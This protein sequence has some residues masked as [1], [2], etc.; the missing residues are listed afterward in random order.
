VPTVSAN[1]IEI[2]YERQ[3]SGPRLLFFNGSG[4]TLRTSGALLL[5]PFAERF[6][7]LAHDQRGLGETSVP[8]GPYTMA[9]YAADG[10]ALLDALGWDTCNVFGV[11]FGGMVAQEFAVTYPSRVTRL[12]LACTS[13]GGAGGS[14]YPLH[15][16]ASMPAPERAAL[17]M[18]LMD[19]RWGPSWFESHPVDKAI[20][21]GYAQRG[22][23]SSPTNERRQLGERL[24]L[25][26]RSRH[27]VWERLPAITCPTLVAG[28]RFDGIAPPENS[29][30]IAS[31]VTGSTLRMYDGGHLFMVQDPA[32]MPDIVEF[33][34][35]SSE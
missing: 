24:Q 21:E 17:A 34:S 26:A 23:G 13:P 15:E 22:A 16:L 27:D 7:V 19:S 35:A 18:T 11:S 20:A 8:E 32:A 2:Y 12:A 1:G 25:E 14:S 3:G 9:D 29:A 28:G 33:L 4:A 10:A 31:R 5:R 6:D 30:A